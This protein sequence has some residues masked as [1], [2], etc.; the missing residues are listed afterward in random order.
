MKKLVLI[1]YVMTAFAACKSSDSSSP[2]TVLD[3]MFT[4]MKNGNMDDM[5]KFITKS[6]VNLIETGEKL[7][8]SADP[9][10]LD[11][12]KTKMSGEFK[13]KAKSVSYTLKNEKI[14]GDNA[15]VEAEVTENGKTSSHKF[16]LVKEDGAWKIAITKPGNE[17]F[18][19]MKGN[20]GADNKDLQEGLER[21]KNMPPDS[22]KMLLNKGM[23]AWDSLDKA[24]K[25]D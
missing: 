2:T 9:E 24:D 22:L 14:D 8:N 13:E 16:D 20:M 11:K 19:S 5:K 21:L 12:M 10:T 4:A 18:N 3:G 17:M 6:D 1:L 15:T 25:K 23:Q 7:I